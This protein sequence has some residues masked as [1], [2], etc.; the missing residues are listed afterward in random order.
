VQSSTTGQSVTIPVTLAINPAP[1]VI[2]LSQTGLTFTAVAQGG[3]VIPQSFGILNIGAGSMN[4]TATAQTI[5]GKGW[6]SLSPISGTVNRP[7]LDVSF[8]NVSVN[9]QALAAGQYYG[10]VQVKAP[11]ASNSPQTVVIVLNVLPA[12]SNPGPQL[13]PSGLV[14]T[15]IAGGTNPGSQAVTVANVTSTPIV[16]GSGMTYVSAPNWI[17]YLPA[18]GT[19]NPNTPA[20]ITVQLNL[21]SLAPGVYRAVLTIAFDDG[22][23]RNVSIL[24]VVAP[25]GT[26]PAVRHQVG[27]ARTGALEQTG[28]CTPTKLVPTFTQLGTGPVVPTGWP[29]ALVAVVVDDCGSPMTSGSAVVSFTD[30]DSP[31][32]MISLG[33]GQWSATWQPQNSSPA[34]VT[35]SLLAQEPGLTGNIQTLVGFQG[36]QTLP[37]ASGGVVNAVTLQAGPLAPGE[38]ILI[39][40]SGLADT[41]AVA[42]VTPLSQQLAGASVYMGG[43]FANLL[44]ANS[45]QLIGQVPFS[46]PVNT[47]QQILLQRDN[48]LGVPNATIVAAAQPAV[49]TADGSGTGQALVY[50]A[51][52][53]GQAVNLANSS[54]PVQPGGTV[55]IYCAGLGAVD[56]QGNVSNPVSVF[57]GGQNAP[58]AY[59]GVALPASYPAGGA[60]M[61]LGVVSS[62]LGGLYQITAMV[63]GGIAAGP[64]TVI[65]GSANQ[66][67]QTGVTMIVGGQG[68]ATPPSI[69]PGGVV[70]AASYAA[71]PVSPGALVAIFTS[72]LA[73]QPASFSTASLPPILG[74]VSVT[75][76]GITA[77][78]VGVSPS[79]AY[80][81]ISAQVPFEVLVAGQTSATVP[82]V[83][84]VNGV[85]S[86]AAQTPIVPSSPGIFT[87]PPTG[88]GNAVLVNLSDYSIAAP[89]GSIPGLTAHPIARGQTAFFYVTG[90][91]AMTPSVAD[92]SGTCPAA[93]GLCNANA[94]PTLLVGGVPAQASAVQAPGFP[95][96]VQINIAIPQTAPTGSNIPL[97]VKSK[98][99]TVTSNTATIAIQ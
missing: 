29:T 74:G 93:N 91:G 60:P 99:G 30:G 27:L 1:A 2:L 31:L 25:A 24:G 47:S 17:T 10:S 26:T 62:G 58:V 9:A 16:Y 95:G 38:L 71:L 85:P 12:G 72:A 4:W 14:F 5:S 8:L 70:N 98:D 59:A 21:A 36:A 22:S 15:G 84:T 20:S 51:N 97:I 94:L 64:A 46:V 44:Y 79:G 87:I 42:T 90:L 96:V 7:F 53:D 63:P 11:G 39:K 28:G 82:V 50:Q 56:Q 73:A 57:I 54:N 80:P 66:T 45:N 75:F 40:G 76:N 69:T 37:T 61:L 65:L 55:I 48:T 41:Q 83:V 67:S 49:F 3:S 86:A 43:A 32:S 89:S 92:G 13:L 78:I 77:P 52:A 33:N 34:G 18:N 35:V 19:V 23:V 68:S 81:F 88:Q 6:L